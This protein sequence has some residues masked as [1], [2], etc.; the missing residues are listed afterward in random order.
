M[1]LMN[2]SIKNPWISLRMFKPK[3]TKKT[4]KKRKRER[5]E[6]KRKKRKKMPTKRKTAFSSM[7]IPSR[8]YHPLITLR[9][10]TLPKVAPKVWTGVKITS[11]SNHQ[12]MIRG[13][14]TRWVF[15]TMNTNVNEN[16]IKLPPLSGWTIRMENGQEKNGQLKNGLNGM[17]GMTT[18]I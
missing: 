17:N 14:M 1:N 12:M 10:Q 16:S 15:E 18:I 6:L 2:G 3:K 5:N 4:K 13:P 7:T 9:Y 8:P 11:S